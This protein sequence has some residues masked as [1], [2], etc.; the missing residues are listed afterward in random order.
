MSCVN[1]ILAKPKIKIPTS[2]SFKN[3]KEHVQD[4]LITAKLTFLITVAKSFLPFLTKFKTVKPIRPIVAE[5]PHSILSSTLN[6]FVKKDVLEEASTP[7]KM[8]N[9]CVFDKENLLPS[10]K[11]NSGF[12]SKIIVQEV[13]GKKKASMLQVHE[14]QSEYEYLVLLENY[15]ASC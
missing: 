8:A 9:I 10:K 5:K 2:Q 3:L 14:L 15:A 4:H 11:I 1:C 12:T 13:K 6:R 7:S